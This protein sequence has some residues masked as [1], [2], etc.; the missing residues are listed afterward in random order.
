MRTVSGS[1]GKSDVPGLGVEYCGLCRVRDQSIGEDTSP[2]SH[3]VG[4]ATDPECH[5]STRAGEEPGDAPGV[6]PVRLRGGARLVRRLLRHAGA[7]DVGARLCADQQPDADQLADVH[8]RQQLQQSA[9]G[10]PQ[11]RPEFTPHAI[12]S[13]GTWRGSSAHAYGSPT[14]ESCCCSCTGGSTT[15]MPRASWMGPLVA[16]PACCRQQFSS[17]CTAF[18]H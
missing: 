12:T 3:R 5:A 16:L 11:V 8:V 6:L 13:R 1:K 17:S 7:A 15:S 2:P 14:A 18:S 4:F 9:S 10:P